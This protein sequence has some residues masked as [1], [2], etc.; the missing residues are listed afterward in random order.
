MPSI[1]ALRPIVA[2]KVPSCLHMINVAVEA[3]DEPNTSDESSG[4]QHQLGV[5]PQAG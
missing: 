2:G 3:V 1:A 4:A 5:V